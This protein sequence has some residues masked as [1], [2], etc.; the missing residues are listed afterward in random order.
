MKTRFH[1]LCDWCDQPAVQR[2]QETYVDALLRDRE[3]WEFGCG[4]HA[5]RY[6]R[7]DALAVP[8]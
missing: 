6:F 4:Y 7:A 5:A 1:V 8:A 2:Q 3:R